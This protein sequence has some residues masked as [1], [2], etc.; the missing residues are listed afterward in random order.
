[1]IEELEAYA[2]ESGVDDLFRDM[3][4][5][6][7]KARPSAPVTYV[8]EYLA[9]AYPEE[10]LTHARAFVDAKDGVPDDAKL[11]EEGCK[12]DVAAE[13]VV[14]APLTAEKVLASDDAHR[15]A[16]ASEQETAESDDDDS[17]EEFEEEAEEIGEAE[18]APTIDAETPI[19]EELLGCE[20]FVEVDSTAIAQD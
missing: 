10:S 16:P 13:I 7:F 17:P 18:D 14:D 19:G 2:R 12:I 11:S 15:A 5:G 6:C 3:M 20:E 4:T 8:L 1:M 9:S